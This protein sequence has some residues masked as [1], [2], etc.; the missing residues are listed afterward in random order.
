MNNH[1]NELLS[2]SKQVEQA[3]QNNQPVIALESTIIAHGMPFPQ[4]L[5]V[6]RKLEEIAKKN[7]VVPAT[8]SLMDGKIKIGLN[9]QEL[10]ELA[11]SKNTRKV[12]SREIANVLA[13]KEMG[14]TTVSATMIAANMAGIK[15]FATGGIGGVHRFA[16]QTFDISAD[17]FELSK[18]PVIVV[19]AGAKAILDLS[20]TL[21][22]LETIGV[23]VLGFQ[24]EFF[25]AFYSAK[26]NL[27]IEKID[28][29]KQIAKIYKLNRELGFTNGML[30]ANPIPQ[31]YEIPFDEMDK[32]ITIAIKEVEKKEITGQNVTPFLL[33]KMVEL[34]E[35]KSLAAN[36]KLVEN[37]VRLACEIAKEF[38]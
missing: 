25:P 23:P 13:K 30:I 27:K 21:E 33:R 34:T 14:A 11:S 37:N 16:E 9:Q 1:K 19:S 7:K 4:N 29:V 8:I 5:E 31:K 32:F 35:G 20:K 26:T 22:I 2:I 12:S 3:L 17:L 10:E 36:V 6:A 18:T 38:V 15:V 24:T 28:T